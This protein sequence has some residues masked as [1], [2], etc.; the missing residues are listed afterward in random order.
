MKVAASEEA[1]EN[2]LQAL[3]K[4]AKAAREIQF[5]AN[6]APLFEAIEALDAL[7]PEGPDDR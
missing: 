1:P 3:R 7:Q 6:Y 4:V 5:C 2:E